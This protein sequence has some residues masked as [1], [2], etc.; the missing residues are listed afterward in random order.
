MERLEPK[1]K[2]RIICVLW[3]CAILLCTMFIV[4]NSVASNE[5]SHSY[6][7]SV[8]EMLTPN[9]DG[10]ADAQ[11]IEYLVRK[12]AHLIEFSALGFVVMCFCTYAKKHYDKAICGFAFFYVLAIAVADEHIQS[13]SGRNSATGDIILDFCGGLIGFFLGWITVLVYTAIKHRYNKRK[14]QRR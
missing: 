5:V 13:F 10:K 9:K 3:V 2:Q 4:L 6:S 8:V 7:D 1:V 12:A 11:E 14:R